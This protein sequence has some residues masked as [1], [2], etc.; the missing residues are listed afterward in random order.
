MHCQILVIHL[1][2]ADVASAT[3]PLRELPINTHWD[4]RRINLLVRSS[5]GVNA[6]FGMD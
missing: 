4:S 2:A 3:G 5:L 1:K 6:M